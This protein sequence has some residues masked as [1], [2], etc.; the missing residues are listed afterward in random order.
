MSRPDFD[1]ISVFAARFRR[2]I[3]AAC[4]SAAILAVLFWRNGIF[5]GGFETAADVYMALSDSTF[6]VG[7]LFLC[8]GVLIL[9]AK[10]GTFNFFSY[11]GRAVLGFFIPS[12]REP[13]RAPYHQYITAKAEERK[14]WKTSHIFIIGAIYCAVGLIFFLL[15]NAK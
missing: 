11:N 8:V 2:V 12:R 6:G 13:R 1:R 4:V 10:S 3:I 5:S 9:S 7:I 14:K 15:Y